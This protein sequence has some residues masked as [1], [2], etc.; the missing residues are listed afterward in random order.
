[1]HKEK[2]WMWW[3]AEST[4]CCFPEGPKL[5]APFHPFPFP[6]AFAEAALHGHKLSVSA[7]VFAHS[8]SNQPSNTA[9][10]CYSS[11]TT[12]HMQWQT[13]AHMCIEKTCPAPPLSI[14]LDVPRPAFLSYSCSAGRNWYLMQGDCL[15]LQAPSSGSGESF[16]ALCPFSKVGKQHLCYY[17]TH[18]AHVTNWL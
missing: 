11:G 13:L 10:H 15:S 6:P 14:Y 2:N 17:S 3:I 7:S 12:V 9:L 18:K 4:G 8:K 5:I 16:F 1:M